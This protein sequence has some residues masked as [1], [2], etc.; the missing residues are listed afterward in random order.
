MDFIT[1]KPE[2]ARACGAYLTQ[3][4]YA[5]LCA[6]AAAGLCA[7]DGGLP[8]GALV[9]TVSGSEAKLL[10]LLADGEFTA[11]EL[12]ERTLEMLDELNAIETVSARFADSPENALLHG[13][14]GSLGF[15]IAETGEKLYAA[16]GYDDAAMLCGTAPPL[17]LP[18][19]ELSQLRLRTAAAAPDLFFGGDTRLLTRGDLIWKASYA[20]LNREGK[21]DGLSLVVEGPTLRS[22]GARRLT[23]Q[24]V[25]VLF[26]ETLRSVV[27]LTP[28]GGRFFLLAPNDTMMRILDIYL[29]DP[30]I[31]LVLRAE[32]HP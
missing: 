15:D 18:L 5:A 12:L 27:G 19:S 11:G 4:S 17:L 22:F 16:Q 25:R 8:L 23:G 20:F 7:L 14:C 13:A 31:S 10:S 28:P 21:I 24:Q 1:L 2:N 26:S 6:G 32:L 9:F 29:K 30:E 3:R